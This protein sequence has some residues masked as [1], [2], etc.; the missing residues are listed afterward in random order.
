MVLDIFIPIIVSII[1]DFCNQSFQIIQSL[2]FSSSI[3]PRIFSIK[4]ALHLP[5]LRKYNKIWN[6]QSQKSSFSLTFHL[7]TIRMSIRNR[8]IIFW[9]NLDFRF[10]FKFHNS[11]RLSQ[12]K[13][14][15]NFG[16][17]LSFSNIHHP[18][19]TSI[20]IQRVLLLI[21][22]ITWRIVFKQF[23]STKILILQGIMLTTI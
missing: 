20:N 17:A 23:L 21:Q 5:I 18:H 1:L 11:M 8:D 15:A 9:V 13:V 6:L 22:N 12:S 10:S 16:L 2:F 19:S 3:L 7:S 14:N 4:I